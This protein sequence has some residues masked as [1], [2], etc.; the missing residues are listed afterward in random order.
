MPKFRLVIWTAAP[1]TQLQHLLRRMLQDVP[2]AEISGIVYEKGPAGGGPGSGFSR[3]PGVVHRTARRLVRLPLRALGGAFDGVLRLLH[4]APRHPNGRPFCR[5]EL[6]RFCRSRNILLR[7]SSPRNRLALLSE[8]S[9]QLR[10]DLIV[11]YG[12]F[13]ADP[14]FAAA[15]RLGALLVSPPPVDP[16]GALDLAPSSPAG[17]PEGGEV[18]VRAEQF[19]DGANGPQLL[20][21][22]GF[23]LH[24]YDTPASTA[25][26]TNLLGIDCT[27]EAVRALLPTPPPGCPPTPVPRLPKV[28]SRN[29]TPGPARNGTPGPARY[30]AGY[31]RPLYKLLVRTLFY[32]LLWVRNLRYALRKRFPVVILFHHVITDRPAYLGMPT[33]QFLKQVR[34]LKKHYKIASLPEAMDMLK[35]KQVAAPTVVLTFDDGYEDNF[36]CLRA[37]AEMENVSVTLFVCTEIVAGGGAFPHDLGRGEDGFRALSWD[38]VRYLRAHNVVIGSHTRTH[39]DCGSGDRGRLESEIGGARE[40][41]RREL[42]QEVPYFSFP[43]GKAKNMPAEALEVAAATYP[44]LFA[45]SGGANGGLPAPE[46]PLS[47]SNHPSSLLELELTLQSVLNF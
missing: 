37:I 2:D 13:S 6:Q 12:D 14:S 15:A 32:P 22:R 41:L 19:L 16:Y 26:K 34:F 43:K 35:N 20:A 7:R 18:V 11:L 28:F 24:P 29:G 45:A 9:A 17:H 25:L 4:W 10:P 36:L 40:D 21:R 5:G 47:R 1:L 38:Q 23:P 44:F 42:G 39:F 27:V 3:P 30:H 46:T 33:E 31:G 8:L